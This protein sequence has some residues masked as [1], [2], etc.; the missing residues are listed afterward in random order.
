MTLILSNDDIRK[1]LKVKECLNVMEET[2]PQPS[3][4]N[5]I[6]TTPFVSKNCR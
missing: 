2:S 1:S 4:K 6:L 3:T 5:S